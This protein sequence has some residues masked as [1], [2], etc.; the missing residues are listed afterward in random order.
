[1]NYNSRMVVFTTL[2]VTCLDHLD[3]ALGLKYSDT[4]EPS[5]ANSLIMYLLAF[6]LQYK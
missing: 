4:P 6:V 5:L 1:M 3:L 2:N